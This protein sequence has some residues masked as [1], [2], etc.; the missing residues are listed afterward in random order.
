M[1]NVRTVL[2]YLHQDGQVPDSYLPHK[3][4]SLNGGFDGVLINLTMISLNSERSA[5][6]INLGTR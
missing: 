1:E 3:F 2:E 4:Y 5:Y 6:I